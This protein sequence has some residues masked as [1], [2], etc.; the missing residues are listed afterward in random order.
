MDDKIIM[1]MFNTILER[2]DNN[3]S[4]IESLK[5]EVHNYSLMV[6][7]MQTDIRTIV[8]VQYDSKS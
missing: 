2:L 3:T 7:G 5:N 1:E 6:E 8:E 4:S